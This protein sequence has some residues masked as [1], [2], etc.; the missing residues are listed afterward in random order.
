MND[1]YL[2][3]Y[4]FVRGEFMNRFMGKMLRDDYTYFTMAEVTEIIEET[5]REVE[6]IIRGDIS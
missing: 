6:D 4:Q 1:T 2:M 5:K 3:F